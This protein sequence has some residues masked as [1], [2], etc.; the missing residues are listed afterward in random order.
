VK[1]TSASHQHPGKRRSLQLLGTAAAVLALTAA[2]LGQGTAAQAREQTPGSPGVPHAPAVVFSE[3]FEH[4]QGTTPEQITG[5]T[6]AAPVNQTYT[7]NPAWLTAC[8]GWIVSLQNPPTEPSGAG[9]GTWW[10]RAKDLAAALGQWAGGDSGTNHAVSAYTN[11]DPGAGKVQ[12]ETQQPIPLTSAHRFLTFS[13]DAAAQNCNGAHPLLEFSLLDGPVSLPTFSNPIDAC[14]NPGAVIGSTSVGTYAS[15]GSVLFSGSSVGLRLV[16]PQP[17]G[18]G[19]DGAFDNVRLLDATPQ[20]DTSFAADEVPV[21]ESTDFTFTITN[22]SDLASKKGWSFAEQLP[23]G[24]VVADPDSVSTNCTEGEVTTTGS[25]TVHVSG[26]L[27]TGQASCTAS[28][29]V[30]SAHSGTYTLCA[31]A[32]SDPVGVDLPG[33]ATVSFVSLLMDAHAHAAKATGLLPV[34]AVAPSDVTCTEDPGSDDAGIDQLPLGTLGSLGLTSTKAQGSIGDDGTRTATAQ[35]TTAKVQLLGGL[36]SADE[37]EA[38]ATASG[39]I[40]DTVTTGASSVFSGLKVAGVSLSV[41]PAPNTTISL[42]LV[43]SVVINEHKPYGNGKGIT[44]NA[45]HVT[46][47]TGTQLTIGHAN[48]SLTKTPGPCP[49]P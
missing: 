1:S 26:D 11:A 27:D 13:V 48:A 3:D 36:I 41:A 40:G 16:S 30:T 44:V 45:L 8:N 33:C 24:L 10:P 23:P 25:G 49:T 22:T 2:G 31:Q 29:K 6:G 19:N 43:G 38:K 42:P 17:S 12:L 21:G 37:L 35:A 32:I 46:L 7:A 34:P 5:Y 39:R 20:L 18:N 28:V 15:D 4:D 47:L 14:A 9:C